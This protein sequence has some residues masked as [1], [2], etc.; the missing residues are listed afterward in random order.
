MWGQA[1]RPAAGLR[2]RRAAQKRGG[3]PEGL[4]HV[5]NGGYF[6]STENANSTLP[7][8]PPAAT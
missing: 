5:F 7:G 2:P 6:P 8:M 1:F 3:S 4:P